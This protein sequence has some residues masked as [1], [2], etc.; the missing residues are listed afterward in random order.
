MVGNCTR[1]DRVSPE[2]ARPGICEVPVMLR[3]KLLP[4][5]VLYLTTAPSHHP[6]LSVRGPEGLWQIV[7]M[8]CFFL[9]VYVFKFAPASVKWGLHVTPAAVRDLTCSF[10]QHKK[11]PT[12]TS[13]WACPREP[14][15]GEE[16]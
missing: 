12:N 9:Q 5:A 7:Y 6:L 13:E 3:S 14:E 4:A 11:G 15:G 1:E 10:S 16:T 2:G 8:C